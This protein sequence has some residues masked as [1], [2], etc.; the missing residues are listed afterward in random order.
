[1]NTDPDALIITSHSSS[2]NKLGG[3]A[4]GRV[5]SVKEICVDEIEKSEIEKNENVSHDLNSLSISQTDGK[6]VSTALHVPSTS[7]DKK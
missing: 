2:P 3:S 5:I 4:T 7:P 6:F 1:M